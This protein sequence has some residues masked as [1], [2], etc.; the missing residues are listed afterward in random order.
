[1]VL[2]RA[3]HR[4]PLGEPRLIADSRCD[5][6]NKGIA[7]GM[8]VDTPEGDWF[9]ILFGDCGA[10]GRIP[11]LFPLWE[12]DWPVVGAG[13]GMKLCY[14]VPLVPR[15][16]NVLVHG[17][18][19]NHAEN[20]LENFWQWNHNPDDAKWSF[21]AR[22]GWLRLTASPAVGLMDAKNTLSQ[23][24][25]GPQ[26]EFTVGAGRRR[27]G[28]GRPRGPR[29]APVGLRA[30]GR[31]SAGGRLVPALYGKA[32]RDRPYDA[33]DAAGR[34]VHRAALR[35]AGV[36]E[37][38][39]RLP[40]R[41]GAR[42]TPCRFS[43]AEDGVSWRPAGERQKL[44]FNL[45]YFVGTRAGLL[46]RRGFCGLPRFYGASAL[47]YVRGWRG[48]AKWCMMVTE[49]FLEMETRLQERKDSVWIRGLVC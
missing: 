5:C 17:D 6:R 18:S 12:E 19:L 11:F 42:A 25:C 13:E 23:R 4:R 3:F 40:R 34:R 37:S 41:G 43:Y 45:R 7:Q 35:R 26:C 16:E 21:T 49:S 33:A 27:A 39:V 9:M 1:M 20:R 8:A 44:N 30:R 38:G 15:G 28:G 36:L 46:L 10:V 29:R 14:D 48:G 31:G 22:S 47:K 2:P 32:R 24:T